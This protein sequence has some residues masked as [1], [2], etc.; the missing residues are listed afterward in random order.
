PGTRLATYLGPGQV[1]QLNAMTQGQFSHPIANGTAHSILLLLANLPGEVPAFEEIREQVLKEHRRRGNDEA[2]RQ[3]LTQLRD[4][5]DIQT[6][7][8]LLNADGSAP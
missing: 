3:Y 8:A 6:N 1:A 7:K 2:L 5:A 4:D